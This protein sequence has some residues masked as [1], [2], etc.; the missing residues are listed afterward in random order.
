MP[1]S[2]NYRV[3]NPEGLSAACVL[4]SF[5]QWLDLR[6]GEAMDQQMDLAFRDR[7]FDVMPGRAPALI[8]WEHLLLTPGA[9]APKGRAWT[10][11]RLQDGR[12]GD[13]VAAFPAPAADATLLGVFDDTPAIHHH[14][15]RR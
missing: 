14:A 11:Y 8:G 6:I 4:T 7:P 3:A 9:Q 12:L 10:V 15:A 2:R 1:S 5:A 13:A